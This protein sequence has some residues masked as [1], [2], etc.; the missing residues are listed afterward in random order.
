[1]FSDCPN[2][3]MPLN[4]K[5]YR[6]LSPDTPTAQ[7]LACDSQMGKLLSTNFQTN[8]AQ[9]MVALKMMEKTNAQAANT[10]NKIYLGKRII[11]S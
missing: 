1:M 2:E 5:C 7:M 11:R 8:D 10:G 9:I 4:N 6:W 3:F